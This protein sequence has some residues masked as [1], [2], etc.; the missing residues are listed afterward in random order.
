MP[1]V[2]LLEAVMVPVFVAESVLVSKVTVLEFTKF[3][4]AFVRVAEE[5]TS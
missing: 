2:R 4:L 5:Q 1:R 3:M